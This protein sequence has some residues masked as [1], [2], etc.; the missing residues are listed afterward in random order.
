[1]HRAQGILGHSLCVVLQAG[2]AEI[3]HLH[4]AVSQDHDILG[5]DVPVNDPAAVGVLQGAHDLNDEVQGLPPI[6]FTPAGH[7]LLQGN[8]VDELHDNVLCVTAG[9]DIINGHDIG[10]GKLCHSLAL[11]PEAA[12]YLLIFSHI[13]LQDL[14]GYHSVKPVA[15]GPIYISH[16]ARADQLDD[17]IAVIQ[18]FSYVFIHNAIS[19]KCS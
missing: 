4:A 11:I 17:L 1:M 10:V 13:S 3:G 12:A 9:G 7:I 19:F 18:H 8:A 16:A 14:D 6:H 5:L 15:F 2:N